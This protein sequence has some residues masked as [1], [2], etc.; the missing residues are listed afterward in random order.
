MRK[1]KRKWPRIMA[2]VLVMLVLTG[3]VALML[4][5][6]FAP[7]QTLIPQS[8]VKLP[9]NVVAAVLKPMQSAVS[10]VKNGISGYLESWKLSQTI[11]I[12][13][14]QLR[15]QNEEL[16]YKS[17][18]AEELEAENERLEKMLGV[19][20]EYVAME[21]N[22]I[23][24]SVTDKETGN[25][26]QQFTID[27]GAQQGIKEYMAVVNGDGLIGY[28]SEV[29]ETSAQVMS[30]VD[31]RASIGAIIQSSRDQGTIKGTLGLEEEPT[32]RMYYLPANVVPR[33]G[34]TVV[35][36]GVGQPF[37]KGIR[38]GTVRESTR[39]LDE[40]KHYVVVE[41][42]VD[43]MH[44]EEVLVLIYEAPAEAMTEADDGQIDYVPQVLDTPRPQPSIGSQI[45]D[46]NL[47][48]YTPP[49]RS[50]RIPE[51]G[52]TAA[53]EATGAANGDA[54]PMP[55]ATNEPGDWPEDWLELPAETAGAAQ[56]GE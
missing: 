33:P 56:G 42:F 46:P 55:E 24:A 51:E 53:P 49:P 11:E 23:K 17:L 36:S 13:Y 39:Y 30:I 37:P 43:F 3:S 22:P 5:D 7:D 16:M 32:C 44:I 21:M 41:P 18:L 26:F 50:T 4:V 19:Y 48:A 34:D 9:S 29:F 40:N 15:A 20:D 14:N 8:L 12:E 45:E 52:T 47:G 31:S 27:K 10:W 6:S 25:W 28:I 35:T 1:R 54:T 38:I 2:L